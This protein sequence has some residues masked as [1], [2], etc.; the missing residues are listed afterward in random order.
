MRCTSASRKAAWDLRVRCSVPGIA[1]NPVA[2]Q[3]DTL[4]GLSQGN[5]VFGY[6]GKYCGF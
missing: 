3:L 1:E 2:S 6:R 5:V 4:N